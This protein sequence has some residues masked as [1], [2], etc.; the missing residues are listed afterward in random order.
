MAIP[1]LNIKKNKKVDVSD[2]P[3]SFSWEKYLGEPGKQS[4]FGSFYAIST[5]IMLKA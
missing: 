2:L 4:S 3:T 5:I 1:K